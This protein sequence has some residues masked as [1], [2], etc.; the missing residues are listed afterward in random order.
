MGRL[1]YVL[2]SGHTWRWTL[3]AVTV[4]MPETVEWITLHSSRSTVWVHW[5]IHR[6]E[7]HPHFVTSTRPRPRHYCPYLLF[8]KAALAVRFHTLCLNWQVTVGCQE[9]MT[10]VLLLSPPLSGFEVNDLS[11]PVSIY[12][13]HYCRFRRGTHT[14]SHLTDQPGNFLMMSKFF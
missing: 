3:S 6:L 12:R 11:P 2:V 9:E 4:E 10:P 7:L 13:P 5:R 8:P 14:S 1:H